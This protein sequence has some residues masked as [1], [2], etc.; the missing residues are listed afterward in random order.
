MNKG[1]W[2][3]GED[4]AIMALRLFT[5]L[6]LR[7]IGAAVGRTASS[8]NTRMNMKG[9]RANGWRARLFDALTNDK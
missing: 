1:S 5:D 4:L 8:V 7:E 9:M 2:T 6:S 3:R